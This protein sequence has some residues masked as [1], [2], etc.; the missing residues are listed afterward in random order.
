MD[1]KKVL[2]IVEDEPE[3]AASLKEIL[4]PT[5]DR[6]LWAEN[7][8]EALKIIRA[9][10]DLTAIL[11]DI[12]MPKM[13]GLQLLAEIRSQFN[14]I[15]FVV[16]SGHGDYAAYQEAVKLNATDFLQKPFDIDNLVEVISKAIHYGVE[17]LKIQDEVDELISSID[18][19]PEKIATLKRLKRTTLAMRAESSIYNKKKQS[20]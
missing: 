12:K 3:L 16:L 18:I 2:L 7:G 19:P 13:N 5:C 4:E 10:P 6:V 1:R 17:L 15:P 14:P 8:V 11:S 9:N 20:A